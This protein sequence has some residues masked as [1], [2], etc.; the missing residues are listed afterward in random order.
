MS[1]R[2]T[3]TPKV[4]TFEHVYPGSVSQARRV[5]ADLAAAVACECP[6]AD[7]LVLLASELVANAATHSRSGWP[8]GE[9]TVRAFLYSGDYA[10][11][12]VVDQGG[13]WTGRDGDDRSHGLDIVAAIAGADNWGIDGGSACRTVWFRLDMTEQAS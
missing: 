7:D 6:V 12:E 5:R 1:M 2:A 3:K 4:I 10:W 13:S 11:V 9:F 8:G